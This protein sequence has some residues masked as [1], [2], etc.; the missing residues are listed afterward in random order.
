MGERV[1][2]MPHQPK[3]LTG[4]GTGDIEDDRKGDLAGEGGQ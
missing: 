2:D 3:V 1:S 4:Y